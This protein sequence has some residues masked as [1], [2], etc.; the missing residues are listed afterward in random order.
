MRSRAGGLRFT[1]FYN[2]ARCWPTR[3]AL[4]T[5][6]YAQQIHRDAL[7]ELRGG[8][9]GVRQQWARLLPDFLKPA[10]YRSYH[11]GKWH[12]DGKV[13]AGG[14]DRSLDDEQPGQLLHRARHH[15]AT[16]CRSS[17]PPMKAATTP[18]SP[19]P[20][21]PSS[22][23]RITR[24]NYADKPFFQYI[25]FTRRTSRCTRCRR[26]SQSIATSISPAGTR[27]ARRDSRGRRRWASPTTTL[28]AARARGRPSACASPDALEK[29]GPGEVNRPLPWS[30]LTDEQRRFQATKM[31]IHAAMVDRM[32][33]EIGRVIAQLKAMGAF[34]N[35]LILFA[36]DNGASAEIMVRDGGHDPQRRARQRRDVSLPRPRLLQRVQHAIPPP[37]D[38]GA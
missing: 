18:P 28:S 21:T 20:I 37:Q 3:G 29:L 16:T 27:C 13:L 4:L 31:A 34:D 5:G 6:Y 33:R 9:A 25:A 7:P 8:V 32:D 11:S 24:R 19:P 36:S 12:I 17:R 30:E 23:C 26:T 1:Q 35:T 2:T 10:G 22:A 38:V 15:R 14:F